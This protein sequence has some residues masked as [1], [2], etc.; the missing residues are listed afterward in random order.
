MQVLEENRLVEFRED[1]LL[2]KTFTAGRL[3][4]EPAR[5]LILAFPISPPC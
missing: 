2:I 1:D 5:V 3:S 4:T